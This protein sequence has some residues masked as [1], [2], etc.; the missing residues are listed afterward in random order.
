MRWNTRKQNHTAIMPRNHCEWM[1]KDGRRKKVC[2]SADKRDKLAHG[3]VKEGD[4]KPFVEPE[5]KKL[6]EIAVEVGTDAYELE[7]KVDEPSDSLDQMT[8][9]ELL[10]YAMEHGVDLPNNDRKS[11]IL[12]ACKE[13]EASI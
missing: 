11:E 9:A 5:P 10:E 12:E 6:P 13:I 2:W 1:T 7:A 4:G 3:W 8:K